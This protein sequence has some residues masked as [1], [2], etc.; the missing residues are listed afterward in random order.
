[1]R[2]FASLLSA[3]A[4]FLFVF[5]IAPAA[6]AAPSIFIK[7]EGF[8]AKTG[9]RFVF[10][11]ETTVPILATVRFGTAPGALNETAFVFPAGGTPDRAGMA[12]IDRPLLVGET[13]YWQV[14]D[15][16]TG[17][18]SLVKSFKAANAYTDW[19]P[20]SQSYTIDLVVQ[21]DSQSLPPGIPSD[22]A[23]DDIAAGIN[24]F[25]E[26]LYDATDTYI[27]LGEVLITD[28]NLDYSANAPFFP[29]ACFAGSTNAADV[30]VQTTVPF[31]SHTF[32][33]WSI[34]D[35]CIGF[36]VGRIGQLV[37]PWED[38][39]HFGYVS[40]H[41]M[42][43]YALNAPDLYLANSDADCRS[44]NLDQW[45]G[46]LMHNTGGFNGA[47]WELTELDRNAT[48]T[49]CAHGT[50]PYS[51][52][53][54]RE[55][56]TNVPL[57]PNGPIDHNRDTLARGNEDGGAL[58]IHILDREQATQTSTLRGFVPDD[59][60]APAPG[61]PC[62][63]PG[64]FI[65]SDPKGDSA[66]GLAAGLP[67]HDIRELRIAEP[68]VL[69]PGKVVF[70]LKMEGLQ[71]P[72]PN[73]TWPVVF[74]D[75][76]GAD[77]WVRMQ[78]N[79]AGVVTF[80]SGT[81]TNPTGVTG[82]LPA[83]PTSS[84][85]ADGT[86]RI[87]VTRANIGNPGP[88]QQLTAFLTRVQAGVV[89]PDNMP[90][91]RV[92]S[93]SYTI[94]GSENCSAADNNPP[95]AVDDVA[96][97]SED[98]SV[99]V[100]VLANDSDPD[101]DA[102]S[103]S[104]AGVPANGTATKNPD[105]TVTY[106][107]NLNFN[108]TDSF[109][110]TIGDGK[111]GSDTGT[112]T[113]TVSPQP[114]PPKAV[115]DQATTSLN[116]AVTVAV[117]ANDADPDGDTLTLAGVTDPPNGSAVIVGS[118]VKYTPDTGFTGTDSF[119][120]TISD[121]TSTDV[122]TVV[123]RVLPAGAGTPCIVPGTTVLTDPLGDQTAGGSAYDIR[124]ISAAGRFLS[125]GTL[126]F[127]QKQEGGFNPPPTNSSW[128]IT[129]DHVTTGASTV[130]T[131]YW[132]GMDTFD[133]VGPPTFSYGRLDP[134]L[135]FVTVGA[136]DAGSFTPDGTITIKIAA[137]KVG[138]PAPGT[139]LKNFV[140]R[141]QLFVGVGQA[142]GILLNLDG[143]TNSTSTT[144]PP[145]SFE[146]AACVV[147]SPNGPPSAI[148]DAAS[149]NED[150]AVTVTVL[151]NDTD[152]DGDTLTVTEAT[153]GSNGTTVVNPDN[154]VTYSP[155]P[156]FNGAD[157]FFYTISDGEFTSSASVSITVHPV[158]DPPVAENDFANTRKNKAVN[159]PVLNNDSDP[160]G[161]QISVVSAS[162]P[163]NGTT[164]VNPDGTVTF[165]PRHGFDGDV[166][167]TYTIS[168]GN[169]GEDSATVTVRVGKER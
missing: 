59:G 25:A 6:V 125:D 18:K 88:G 7:T 36:Y 110:Y 57:A 156:N 39:L 116:T 104:S 126:V 123:V 168:D 32:G 63:E 86:I 102:V 3:L 160:E 97:T 122:G 149:T 16:L 46:S 75:Q 147:A 133:P 8:A 136:A 155:N 30:L 15:D 135:G 129:W 23:L 4:I 113:V 40:T 82:L 66:F 157:S 167:F 1:M 131:T 13:I 138:N 72:T 58:E 169:G 117:L 140:G 9:F 85:N 118:Q 120:Y 96:T 84:F 26:R 165:T 81:G 56:Y 73:T 77:R 90:D 83:D 34:D 159:V 112:V 114:D 144:A 65:L 91:S 92:Q 47:A 78:T 106:A 17:D 111:G 67:E 152:P 22:Q 52:D 166:T 153:Q 51:W 27:R 134:T 48:L 162:Q 154:T 44:A 37:V 76:L 20:V 28:T 105:G 5:P 43:H 45:D 141:A 10:A 68:N 2:K 158:N 14:E 74:K 94:I 145:R 61:S 53:A 148:N 119:D 150:S 49:P 109:T 38:D 100:A 143:T 62:K 139:V 79:A 11:W 146:V 33:G 89:T 69:G 95:V 99:T 101:G 93:G 163:V 35:P 124:S 164:T 24:V 50:K 151:A 87:V 121:G 55:R 64:Q 132:V 12:M 108:G 103:V 115:D 19:D 71:N 31:D 142:G 70:T 54:L 60:Q 107:P 41:E 21:L 137:V 127:T 128:R 42:A 130:T 80:S 161:D 98:S 29:A